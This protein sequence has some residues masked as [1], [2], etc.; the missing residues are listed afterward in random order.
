MLSEI[1]RD[2]ININTYWIR[3]RDLDLEILSEIR[4]ALN[5]YCVRL[6]EA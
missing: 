5:R 4:R 3:L 6:N 1:K 2:K